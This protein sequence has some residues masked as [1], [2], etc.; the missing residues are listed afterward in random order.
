[1]S[2]VAREANETDNKE[3]S[4]SGVNGTQREESRSSVFSRGKAPTT[5][6][7]WGVLRRA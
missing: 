2:E 6:D 5:G 3:G 4:V 7:G 1:M